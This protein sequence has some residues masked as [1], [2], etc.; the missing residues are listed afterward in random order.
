MLNSELMSQ[1]DPHVPQCRRDIGGLAGSR[2]SS[3]EGTCCCWPRQTARDGLR[4]A[5]T[6]GNDH[7]QLSR[8]CRFLIIPFPSAVER[9]GSS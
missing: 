8:G 1:S 2:F 6:S 7:L 9:H 5:S 4:R 3:Q